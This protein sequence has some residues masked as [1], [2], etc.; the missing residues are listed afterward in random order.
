MP[1][2]IN[3]T[4]DSRIGFASTTLGQFT[5][6]LDG[7]HVAPANRI[8]YVVPVMSGFT[9]SLEG[10]SSSTV[11]PIDGDITTTIDPFNLRI[12]GNQIQNI[13]GSVSTSIGAFSVNFKNLTF[14]IG[15]I[16]F[17][18]TAGNQQHDLQQYYL[19]SIPAGET[20]TN[21]ALS[22]DSAG[23]PTGVTINVANKSLDFDDTTGGV[24]A[25][26]GVK[27]DVTTVQE[28]TSFTLTES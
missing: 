3:G 20:V 22:S 6:D 27:I 17:I 2:T 24:A 7:T 1:I 23:L 19:S 26:T 5:A 11:P 14:S 21:I 16:S 10:Q 4:T 28:L 8:G 12:I 13:A 9:V 25:V 18:D 15:T